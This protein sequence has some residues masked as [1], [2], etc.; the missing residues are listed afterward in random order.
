MTTTCPPAC[1]AHCH[2]NDC[3][4]TIAAKARRT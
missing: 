2:A 1:T 4:V 3:P